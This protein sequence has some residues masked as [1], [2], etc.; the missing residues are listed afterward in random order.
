M[1]TG[2]DP[3]SARITSVRS[4]LA[5]AG[6]DALLVTGRAN[7]RYLTGFSGSNAL[8]VV[9]LDDVVLLTDFRYR[10]QAAAEAGDI[11]DIEIEGSSLWTRLWAVLPRLRGVGEL[12]FESPH[13]MTLDHQ[14]LMDGG[15]RWQW[16]ATAGIVEALRERKDATELASIRQA[17]RIAEAALDV[18]VPRIRAG[19]TELEVGGLLEG[20]LRSHGSEAH[21]FETIVASGERAALPHARC[22]PRPLGA[23]DLVIIDFGA[24]SGG[25][26][27]DITRTFVV[28]KATAE[29]REAYDIVR[30]ANATAAHGVRAGMRGRDADLLAREYIERRGRG[31]EFGHSLGHGIG[32]EVH[33]APRLA[34]SADAP[35]PLGAVVTIEPGI[36]RDGWGGIRIE[37][38]VHLGENGPVVLTGFSRDLVE[39]PA[40]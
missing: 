31:A 1:T 5:S 2:I 14:R 17:V 35:L 26:C 8:L 15:S 34:K 36:Y 27:S 21:P 4:E 12:G 16:R 19:L 29:Q 23:G 32:L 22:T 11:A 20:A 18:T 28:G 9:S 13:L 33:E 24:T 3:R 6:L 10:S 38:D 30:E 25:Y 37:D 40:R 7:V 39:L